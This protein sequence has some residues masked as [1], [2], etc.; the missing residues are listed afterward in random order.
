MEAK[1]SKKPIRER[2]STP[3]YNF[4]QSHTWHAVFFFSHFLFSAFW[5]MQNRQ[6]YSH[7]QNAIQYISNHAAVNKT[8]TTKVHIADK[9]NIYLHVCGEGGG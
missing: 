2:D 5:K 8:T 3:L 1:H 4:S 6:K 9:T 7:F